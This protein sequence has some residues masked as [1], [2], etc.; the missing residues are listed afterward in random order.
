MREKYFRQMREGARAF[1]AAVFCFAVFVFVC[2]LF[3]GTTGGG[4]LVIRTPDNWY[5][6]VRV[7]LTALLASAMGTLAYRR[8]YSRP[9]VGA[10]A[11]GL[12]FLSL[13]PMS[14]WEQVS[15]MSSVLPAMSAA[16]QAK[17]SRLPE[18]YTEWMS[19]RAFAMARRVKLYWVHYIAYLLWTVVTLYSGYLGQYL[20]G[21]T[22]FKKESREESAIYIAENA[23]V[24]LLSSLLGGVAAILLAAVLSYVAVPV[25][26]ETPKQGV[27]GVAALKDAG[28]GTA[29]AQTASAAE[30]ALR[31]APS[32]TP[33]E[34]VRIYLLLVA[35]SF[36][37]TAYIGAL[38]A[39]PRTSTW[40]ACGAIV[41]VA[42]LPVAASRYMISPEAP[43]AFFRILELSPFALAGTAVASALLGD[44]VAKMLIARGS[45]R[46]RQQYRPL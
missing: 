41:G 12:V 29:A 43:T 17:A 37:L 36:F 7:S 21:L 24:G 35:L 22:I 38:S 28:R 18:F 14:V 9:M 40:V 16:E 31:K 32:R 34:R 19:L 42:A 45:A 4:G 11:V 30:A 2:N 20:A 33:V 13:D 25:L 8:P 10:L 23:G 39:K 3:S 27:S 44:W 1:L 6:G 46:K 15:R 5:D 26:L